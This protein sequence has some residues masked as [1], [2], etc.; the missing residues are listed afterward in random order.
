MSKRHVPRKAPTRR[1]ALAVALAV[2]LGFTSFAYAQSTTGQIF[3]KAPAASGQTVQ[4]TGVAGTVRTVTVG[5]DGS[6]SLRNLPVGS[7]TVNLMN[8]GEVVA[9]REITVTPGGGS[10][11][12]F[13]GANVTQLATV[14]VNASSVPTI[15]VSSVASSYTITAEQ[16]NQLPIGRSAEAIALLS[17]GVVP[18]SGYFGNAITVAG[19]GATENAYYVNGYNT[20]ALYDYTGSAYQLPYGTIAQQETIIGGY[21]AKYGRADG[22]VIN[23]IGKR[24]TNEWHFGAQATWEP[25]TLH[26][27]PRNTYFPSLSLLPGEETNDQNHTA[28]DLYQNRSNNKQWT[29]VY[30]AY[31]GGPVVQDKLYFYVG[32]ETDR[33]NRNTVASVNTNQVNESAG[34]DTRWY[35]K[36]DWNINENNHFEYTQLKDDNKFGYGSTYKYNNTTNAKGGLVGENSYDE[37]HN[38]TRIFHYTG[39]LSDAA[40]LSVLYG[41]TNVDN[42]FLLP[43]P[44]SQPFISAAGSQNPALN[45]GT[46]IRNNQ[47]VATINSPERSSRSKSLRMDLDYQLGDHLLQV[48]IDN[49]D[50]SASNQG[51]ARSGPGYVWIY[52]ASSKPNSPI[53][54]SLGVGAPGGNGFYVYRDIFN[55]LTGLGAKQEAYY[56]QDQWQVTSNVLLK[57]GVRNDK[58]SNSNG[59]GQDFVVQKNQWEPRIGATWDVNGDSTLKIYGNVGRYYLALPQSVGE[60]AATQSTFTDEYFTYTGIDANGIPTGLTPVPGVNGAPPPGPVSANH[61]FGTAPDPK[62]VASTNLKPQYQDEFILGFDK[63][64]GADWAYGAKLTYR[65]LGTVIDD[66][67]FEDA[68]NVVDDAIGAMGL[69]PTKYNTVDPGCRIFNPNRTNEF[70]VASNDG[71]P[72]IKVPITQQA[73]GMPDVQRD[74]YGLDLF[75]AH[76]FDGVW[77]GRIDYTF[78]RSWGNAE[79]QV[80][81]DIGQTDTSK[82]EDWDYWQLMSGARGYL[83][84]DRRHSLKAH[85]YWQISPEWSVSGNLVLQ[86]GAPFSCLGMFGPD[87]T[88]PGGGYGSDYH[89]CRGKISPPGETTT[90]WMKQLNLGVMYQPAFA[91]RKLSLKAQVINVTDEQVARQLDPHLLN[92]PGSAANATFRMPIYYQTP[93]YVQF[94]VAY[95]Y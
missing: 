46:P 84:N 69:D 15:D 73:L 83:A 62:L 26:A 25:R 6:Y 52:G 42:P 38:D 79:G 17:P 27:D 29:T 9:T 19:A 33:Y 14:Q 59:D 64:W 53:N 67:C 95:D 89:W 71:S 72:A 40:T 37:Y 85:G 2:G 93:R 86:S 80:R 30:S 87:E 43:N 66:V 32:V 65:T 16:L 94:S 4:A 88:N 48:G 23:Q 13:S 57:L 18:S 3:G 92:R 50:Y 75:L 61:E 60:R 81:S 21:D 70:L 76:P 55:T 10:E 12:D 45:G 68:P 41:Y 8:K 1:N 39:Y 56:L 78:S 22:G 24:G 91:Q 47:T 44:S 82:T 31:A 5:A 28:G 51:R 74:Y 63:T 7:Y 35:G 20:T 11:I 49:V 36:I 58:F 90:P 77:S 34:H 54:E